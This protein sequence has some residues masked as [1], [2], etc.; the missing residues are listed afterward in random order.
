MKQLKS[1][2]VLKEEKKS[3]STIEPHRRHSY[4]HVI[5]EGAKST[6]DY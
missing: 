1:H 3:T 5:A 2:A 4:R 6:K